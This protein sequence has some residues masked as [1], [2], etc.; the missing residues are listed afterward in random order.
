M[1]IKQFEKNTVGKDYF[2]GD[3]HGMFSLLKQELDKIGFDRSKDRLFSVGDLV[4]RGPNSEDAI[5]W[6]D[7]PWFHAV[8]G[9]HEQMAVDYFKP[10]TGWNMDKHTYEYNGGEWFINLPIEKQAV[11]ASAFDELPMAIEVV[12]DMG[13]VG[14]VHAE[15]IDD[16]W[17]KTKTYLFTQ[18]AIAANVMM[19][20]RDKI[21]Y[22]NTDPVKGI[23][24]VIVGHTP[25]NHM[26]VLGN[27]IY[28]D[29]GAVYGARGHFTIL[30]GSTLHAVN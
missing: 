27:V 26:K 21:R 19:W 14:V 15:A 9:N 8:R 10:G 2:V 18:P 6:L 20:N 1:K 11:F 22:N 13:R 17:D 4:D 24:Y 29:T 3:I 23:D 30:D 16:D 28:I 5:N 7:Q 25:Q 12:T